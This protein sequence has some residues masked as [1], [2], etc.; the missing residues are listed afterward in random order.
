VSFI[1]K[2]ED[3]A[4]E[5]LANVIRVAM[6]QFFDHCISKIAVLIKDHYEKI[7]NSGY[8]AKVSIFCSC[9]YNSANYRRTSSLWGVSGSHPIS[10]HN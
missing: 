6:C 2:S 8:M 3:R 4:Y 10:R 9:Y 5:G 1:H 7:D